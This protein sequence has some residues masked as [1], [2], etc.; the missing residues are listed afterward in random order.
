MPGEEVN[1]E[2]PY[3]HCDARNVQAHREVSCV[4]LSQTGDSVQEARSQWIE[5]MLQCIVVLQ[6]ILYISI[7]EGNI[8]RVT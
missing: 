3:S 5:K 2:V 7:K 4:Y 8:R 6:L 1:M